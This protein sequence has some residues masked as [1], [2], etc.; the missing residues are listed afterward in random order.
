MPS[1]RIVIRIS[2]LRCWINFCLHEH[3]TMRAEKC[4]EQEM[5]I[6]ESTWVHG[7]HESWWWEGGVMV[8]GVW[9]IY[10]LHPHHSWRRWWKWCIMWERN[11]LFLYWWVASDLGQKRDHKKLTIHGPHLC[12]GSVFERY[13]VCNIIFAVLGKNQGRKG[14]KESPFSLTGGSS[15]EGGSWATECDIL[16]SKR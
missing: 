3:R 4:Q 15:K 6:D 1:L 16:T 11:S 7:V 2:S 5:S 14:W 10:F 13:T 12:S 9:T 8:R